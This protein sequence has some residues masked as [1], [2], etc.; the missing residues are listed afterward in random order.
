[1]PSPDGKSVMHAEMMIGDSQL[2][3][4]DEAPHWGVLSPLALGGTGS[5]V[6]MQVENVDALFA[7][8]VAAGAKPTMPPADMF[9]GD[10]FAKVT[11]P[12][13]HEWSIATHIE[14]VPPEQLKD[15][16]IAAFAKMKG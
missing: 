10:R 6:H 4:S 14:D 1:M 15:R 7:S 13:G 5:V 12:F 16:A 3:M 2:M 11:D 8:A 9:W